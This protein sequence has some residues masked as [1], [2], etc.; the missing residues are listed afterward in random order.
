MNLK[1]GYNTLIQGGLTP[2]EIALKGQLK[3]KL[4]D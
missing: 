3:E 4:K 2:E 1:A